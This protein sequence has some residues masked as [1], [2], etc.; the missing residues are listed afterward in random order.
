MTLTNVFVITAHTDASDHYGPWVFNKKPTDAQLEAFLRKNC[1][2]EFPRANHRHDLDG[3]ADGAF[4]SFL[5]LDITEVKV[6]FVE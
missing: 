4:G 1:P 2:N 6:N 3:D 5:Y